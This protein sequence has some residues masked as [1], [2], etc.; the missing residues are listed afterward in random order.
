MAIQRGAEAATKQSN[1]SFAK[2]PYFGIEDGES[3]TVRFLTDAEAE[4]TPDGPVGGWLTVQMHQSVPTKGKPADSKAQSWPS[5]MPAVCRTDLDFPECFI[6]ESVMPVNKQVKRS[7]RSWALLVVRE[8]VKNADGTIKGYRDKKRSVTREV[9]GKEVTTEELDIQVANM[10]GKNFFKPLRGFY[11]H[12]G[13][14]L[15]RDYVITR[16]GEGTDTTYTIIPLDPIQAKVGDKTEVYD[17]RNPE[18]MKKYLPSAETVGYALASDELLVPIVEG[19]GSADYYATFF[20]TRV[21][22]PSRSS[23]DSEAPSAPAANVPPA[24]SNDVVDPVALGDLQSRIMSYGNTETPAEEAP[25][26]ASQEP[27]YALD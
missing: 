6:C 16:D 17:L 20:D 14:V 1:K 4:N 25:A 5:R 2:T 22:A 11:G 26:D 12:F 8:E 7:K 15:D 23:D 3:A 13:T 24:P 9:D 18:F 21:Q 10:G 19:R 27:V